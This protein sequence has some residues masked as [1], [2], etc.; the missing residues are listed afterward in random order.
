MVLFTQVTKNTTFKI[1]SCS[2]LN[3]WIISTI[4]QTYRRQRNIRIFT[5]IRTKFP[6]LFPHALSPSASLSWSKAV[7]EEEEEEIRNKRSR[8]ILRAAFFSHCVFTLFMLWT[9]PPPSFFHAVATYYTGKCYA[10]EIV[11]WVSFI[12]SFIK[13]SQQKH[14]QSS[15]QATF[16]TL[17]LPRRWI[18][19]T[20]WEER[21]V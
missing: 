9:L 12:L 4:P 10:N 7:I 13:V 8:A 20:C 11:P 1:K 15:L 3:G 5:N 16:V 6:S 17:F 14:S 2:N 21:N 19:N 18:I